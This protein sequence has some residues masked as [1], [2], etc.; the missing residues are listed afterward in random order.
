MTSPRNTASII[1]GHTAPEWINSPSLQEYGT[2]EQLA[3]LNGALAEAKKSIRNPQKTKKVTITAKSGGKLYDYHYAP[4]T[5]LVDAT[6]QG[7]SDNGL[8]ITQ[9]FCLVDWIP[10]ADPK[11]EIISRALHGG[12]V[13]I[14]KTA[15]DLLP[16]LPSPRPERL[17]KL[18]T[19][20]SHKNGGR[21]VSAITF[22]P[23]EDIKNLGGQ[24]TYFARYAYQ[25]LLGLDGDS[26]LDAEPSREGEG[27]AKVEDRKG[28]AKSA[29]KSKAKSKPKEPKEPEEEAS[30]PQVEVEAQPEPMSEDTVR[31]LSERCRAL[32]LAPL[33][34]SRL[35]RLLVRKSPS[36]L[37]DEDGMYMLSAL[38][39]FSDREAVIKY[40]D[41]Q[42]GS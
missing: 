34:R 38:D 36:D 3:A 25:R 37:T 2:P 22:R 12:N 33:E 30:E 13:E 9:P 26:D 40:L 31:Q 18:T 11:L 42:E 5:E 10:P 28:K 4:L 35:A 20:L 41:A 6:Q 32:E 29:G 15:L 21:I 39:R 24:T 23:A 27:G 16:K 17:G 8:S 1:S 14:V 19:I 7:L